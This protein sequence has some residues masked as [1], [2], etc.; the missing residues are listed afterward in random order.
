MI[1]VTELLLNI[2]R[3]FFDLKPNL[4]QMG[5]SVI[6]VSGTMSQEDY[7]KFENNLVDIASSRPPRTM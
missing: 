5:M 6:P 2:L 3:G 4:T 7:H 1:I